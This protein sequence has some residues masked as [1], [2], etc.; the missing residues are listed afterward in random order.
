MKRVV[1]MLAV[2]IV[3]LSPAAWARTWRVE[4]DGSGDYTIIQ[5]ALDAAASG[6]TIRIGPGR[7]E[8][9]REYQTNG[10]LQ[11]VVAMVPVPE[12]SIIG[13]G[14]DQTIIGPGSY[15]WDGSTP[16]PR[17]IVWIAQPATGRLRIEAISCENLV[18]EIY[19]ENTGPII[20]TDCAIR[21]GLYGIDS[22]V[23]AAVTNCSFA[24]C[25]VGVWVKTPAIYGTVASCQFVD[26]VSQGVIFQAL[27]SGTATDCVFAACSDCNVVGVQFSGGGGGIYDC[28]FQGLLRPISMSSAESPEI[29]R[30]RVTTAGYCLYSNSE[31]FTAE[32]NVFEATGPFAAIQLYSRG[33]PHSIHGNH[34]LRGTGL[35]VQVIYHTGPENYHL[36]LTGNWWGTTDRDSI[37]AWIHD[38][39]DVTW[40]PGGLVECTVDFDPIAEA[41]I[42]TKKESLGGLKA[43]Y[44]GR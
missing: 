26:V 30:N 9:F 3:G 40:P 35:A 33:L 23:S 28:R 31:A 34:I 22:F 8:D 21:G 36:D 32:G 19:A 10:G 18:S 16:S 25:D 29:L 37:S 15:S 11:S 12:L 7:F 4:K 20:V 44:L 38:G 42:P 41:P 2:A 6:D 43:Q 17:G 24:G 27:D 5:D 13:A 14:R 39:N 1:W